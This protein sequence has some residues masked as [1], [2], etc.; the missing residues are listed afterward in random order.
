MA[1][2]KVL[3]SVQFKLLP[4]IVSIATVRPSCSG[5]CAQEYWST[6]WLRARNFSIQVS[7]YI[8]TRMAPHT[9][10]HPA[11]LRGVAL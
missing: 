8:P 5:L 1:E 6:Y 2:L 4:K 10:S 9:P 7:V 3:N 11:T